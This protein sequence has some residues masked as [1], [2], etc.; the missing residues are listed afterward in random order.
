MSSEYKVGQILYVISA[1]KAALIPVRVIERRISETVNGSVVRHI[2]ASPNPKKPNIMLESIKG[3]VFDDI[4]K[5]RNIMMRNAKNSIDKMI[6]DSLLLAKRAFKTSLPS[7]EKSQVENDEWL[8]EVSDADDAN[9]L[10][11]S[12]ENVDSNESDVIDSSQIESA[13]T[14]ASF[15]KDIVDSDGTVEIMSPDGKL[16][17][18]KVKAK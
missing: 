11:E 7:R 15:D 4:E 18:V 16:Q 12:E 1:K 9:N 17:R 13:H 3:F 2:I 6:Q 5:A 14:F 8:D 10:V